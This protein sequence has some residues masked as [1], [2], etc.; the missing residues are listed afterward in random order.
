MRHRISGAE[1]YSRE[2]RAR[3]KKN[4]NQIQD[5]WKRNWEVPKSQPIWRQQLTE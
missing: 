1:F 3:R 5:G 4:P 2:G